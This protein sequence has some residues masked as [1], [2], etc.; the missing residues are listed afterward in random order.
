MR[1]GDEAMVVRYIAIHD[2]SKLLGIIGNDDEMR[3]LGERLRSSA[4]RYGD[5][6]LRVL[7]AH[8]IDGMSY[9]ECARAYAYTRDGIKQIIRCYR[10][11]SKKLYPNLYPNLYPKRG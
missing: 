11:K 5:K 6:R 1:K 8:L 10:M 2:N 9:S 4:N 7:V 3:I